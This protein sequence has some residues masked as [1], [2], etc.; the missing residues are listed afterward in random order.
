M[1]YTKEKKY[2]LPPPSSGGSL[3]REIQMLK[4]KCGLQLSVV[5]IRK[6]KIIK[7]LFSFFSLF[8]GG[9][10]NNFFVPRRRDI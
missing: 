8:R 4:R 9:V 7:Q 10:Y 5:G 2:F 3:I 1:A 6:K